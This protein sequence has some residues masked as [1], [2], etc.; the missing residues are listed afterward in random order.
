MREKAIES[1]IQ[2]GLPFHRSGTVVTI[3]GPRFSTRAESEL[4]RHWGADVINMSTSPEAILAREAGLEYAAIAMATDYDCWKQEEK[5][6][7][8]EQVLSIFNEN[9]TNMKMLLVD[10]IKKISSHSALEKDRNLIKSKI[11][12]V[13]DWPKEG[14]K[15]K[16]ITTL[17]KDSNGLITVTK[18]FWERYKNLDFDLVAGIE[19]RGFIIASALASHF[20]KG[21]VLIRKPCKLP[22]QVIKEEYFLEYGK[23]AVEM[24]KDSI[25][26][27]QKVLLVDDLLATGGTATAASNLIERLGGDV[28]ECAFVIELPYLKGRERLGK[29]SFSI[30]QFDAD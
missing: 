2:L 20:K 24:H 17:L 26:P 8:W 23:D 22:S 9:A 28:V 16:D 19:S 3:E 5:P 30:V 29:P 15:F 14:I 18:V 11:R 27:G 4:F 13:Q 25:T 6:V 1:C 7:S 21:L 12:T 10:I